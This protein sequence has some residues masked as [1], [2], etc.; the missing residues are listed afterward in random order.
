ML[1]DQGIVL[2]HTVVTIG[3]RWKDDSFSLINR[4]LHSRFNA[5]NNILMRLMMRA[6]RDGMQMHVIIFNEANTDLF[7]AQSAGKF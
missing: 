4:L 3:F 6:I 7:T 2:L 5:F 1:P